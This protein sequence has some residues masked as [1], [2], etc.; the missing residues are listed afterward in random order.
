ML[1]KVDFEK[2]YD[3]VDWGYLDDVMGECHSQSCGGNGSKNGLNV[4]MEAA[5]ARNLFTG[6]SIGE[7]DPVTVSYLQF[8]DDTLLLGVK[9]WANVRAL[10]AV[11]VLFETMSGLKVNFHKSMLVGVNIPDYWLGEAASAL[12]C[13]IVWVE[14]LFPFFWWPSGSAKVLLD[15]SSCLCSFL[16]QSSL[17]QVRE[18]NLALLGKWCWRMLVDREGLWFR[19]LAARYGVERGRL[20]DGGRRG[21]SWWKEISRIREGGELGGSWFGE[22]VSKRVGDRSDTYFWTDP[23]VGVDG[24][25]WE[26]RRQLWA[27]EEEMLRECQALLLNLSLQAIMDDADKLIWHS[28]VPLKVSIFAWRLLR[29][30]LPTK[31][32]M[33][34]RGILSPAAHFCIT[35]CGEAESAHHLFIS[36]ST[37][38]SLWTSVCSW[39]DITPVHSAS[40]RDYFVQF[41]CSAGGSRARRSFLQLIW[42][43]CVDGKKSQIIS[44]LNKQLPSVVR[45]DQA[46][47]L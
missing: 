35:G 37:F 22:H 4:L 16:L 23:G 5:V 45:Q 28:H 17:R 6:Y 39:I 46:F 30:R 34:T 33:V 14:E 9:S 44:R 47:F 19:V 38:G 43:V 1:F 10:R 21:S 25:A 13:K 27:C 8:A 36:C 29:D 41:T 3:S 42:L 2:A 12:C 24:E 20:R 31:T 7:R 32:N 11:L 26:W 40:I 15:I 18:F